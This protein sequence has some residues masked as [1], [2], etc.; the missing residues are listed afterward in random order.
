[1]KRHYHLQ[2]KLE[3]ADAVTW[4]AAESISNAERFK[5][6]LESLVSAILLMPER[7]SPSAAGTRKARFKKYPYS[8]IFKQ[9]PTGITIYAV[10]HDKRRPG[11][12]VDRLPHFEES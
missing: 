6:E 2:A 9:Y 5:A 8:V 7:F 4:Y 11:Y 3:L 12:W 10:V 1:V